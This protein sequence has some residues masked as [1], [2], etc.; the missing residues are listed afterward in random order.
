MCFL[1]EDGYYLS[2][3]SYKCYSMNGTKDTD[4]GSDDSK[5]NG[6]NINFA[7]IYLFLALI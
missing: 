7:L 6:I 5:S 2:D 3:R 4:T 1:C